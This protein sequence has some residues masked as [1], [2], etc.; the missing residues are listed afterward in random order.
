MSAHHQVFVR[1][2]LPAARL[3]ADIGAAAQARI[4]PV[5]GGPASFAGDVGHAAVEME[6]CHDF[7]D[8]QDLDFTAYPILITVRDFGRDLA[9]QETLARRLGS[10]L[11]GQGYS[12]L[13]AFDLQQL[14]DRLGP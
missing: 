2:S 9:R 10:A 1:T 11:A 7:E 4:I 5:H 3:I 12:V 8:D 13:V 14:L 6:L